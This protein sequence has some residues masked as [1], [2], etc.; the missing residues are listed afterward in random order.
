MYIDNNMST[1]YNAV[2]PF[3]GASLSIG[4]IIY[5]IGKQ[6]EK[7]EISL[8]KVHALEKKEEH[9]YEIINNIN[10]NMLVINEK[11]K[12]IEEDVRVIKNNIKK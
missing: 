9:S 5:Q 11:L 12:N 10:G 4:G 8:L 3:V 1:I 6:S 2:L 7:I